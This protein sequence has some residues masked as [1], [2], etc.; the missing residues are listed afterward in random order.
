MIFVS[1]IL[2]NQICHFS[3]REV[4]H[5]RSHS[6]SIYTFRIVICQERFTAHCWVVPR[7]RCLSYWD[8]R[9]R[10]HS[11]CC[12]R[13]RFATPPRPLLPFSSFSTWRG[14]LGSLPRSW[15]WSVGWIK[16]SCSARAI[17]RPRY[18]PF[19]DRWGRSA[20]RRGKWQDQPRQ[21]SRIPPLYQIQSW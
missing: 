18:V 4:L 11:Y 21:W 1:L 15:G 13:L 3:L 6:R 8:F 17:P 10:P 20:C 2:P 7:K 9:P 19:S 5:H 14:L 16:C 12:A